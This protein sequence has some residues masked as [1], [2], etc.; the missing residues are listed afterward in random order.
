MKCAEKERE[1]VRAGEYKAVRALEKA[2]EGGAR[3]VQDAAENDEGARVSV[4]ARVREREL[5]GERKREREIEERER[6]YKAVRAVLKAAEGGARED[7][8]D[9][10]AGTR[11]RE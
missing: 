6:K 2:A 1:R 8:A 5:V 9:Y 11:A 3:C 7:A 4:C 10:D